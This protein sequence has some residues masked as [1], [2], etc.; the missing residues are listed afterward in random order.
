MRIGSAILTGWS[1]TCGVFCFFFT[2]KKWRQSPHPAA[3][4]CRTKP[5]WQ[6]ARR[7]APPASDAS[8][9][10]ISS[11]LRRKPFSKSFHSH[12]KQPRRCQK[13]PAKVVE[14]KKKIENSRAEVKTLLLLLPFSLA[15]FVGTLGTWFSTEICKHVEHGFVGKSDK[16]FAGNGLERWGGPTWYV[17]GCCKW[18]STAAEQQKT[19]EKTFRSWRPLVPRRG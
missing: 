6:R 19:N 17:C 9:T 16:I 15:L 1:D 18:L 2:W 13:T 4:A 5:R 10:W 3:A 11:F 12:K 8:G 14:C 7:S